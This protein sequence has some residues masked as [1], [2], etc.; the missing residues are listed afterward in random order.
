M[1]GVSIEVLAQPG[2]VVRFHVTIGWR[3]FGWE[4]C[5]HAARLVARA[6]LERAEQAEA[7]PASAAFTSRGGQS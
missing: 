6:I 7:I 4:L 3:R 2:G 5:A 1:R